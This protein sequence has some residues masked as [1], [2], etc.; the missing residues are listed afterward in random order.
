MSYLIVKEGV[1]RFWDWVG[2]EY[3]EDAKA[4]AGRMDGG[5]F[6]GHRGG[7]RTAGKVENKASRKLDGPFGEVNVPPASAKAVWKDVSGP[8]TIRARSGL[9]GG[10]AKKRG[11][12]F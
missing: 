10:S 4:T 5:V 8:T 3:R 12:M 6:G 1:K 7:A 9:F 2:E 11:V